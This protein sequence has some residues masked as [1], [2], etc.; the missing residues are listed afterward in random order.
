[1]MRMNTDVIMPMVSKNIRSASERLLSITSTSLEK[2]L[3]FSVLHPDDAVTS[4]QDPELVSGQDTAFILKKTEN[5]IV[6]DVS[7]DVG[8]NSTEWVVHEY[9]ISIEVDSSG[10][11][12]T[13]LLTTRD[14]NTT[15][16]D[17]RQITIG[18]HID[19]CLKSATISD[20]S[21]IE[22]VICIN[23]LV[24]FNVEVEILK[25]ERLPLLDKSARIVARRLNLGR[26]SLF[27]LFLLAVLFLASFLLVRFLPSKRSILKSN[28]I[29]SL[30]IKYR[31]F[32]CLFLEQELFNSLNRSPGI[33]YLTQDHR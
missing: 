9:N 3:D 33:N 20:V 21:G 4:A 26:R 15:F 17:F 24:P 2:R 30:C 29:I 13:L 8:V 6:E 5:S 14:G 28:R 12:E 11:V 10:N 7:S 1:M 22:I 19:I 25:L 27:G 31:V 32:N 23:E 18:K 16:A